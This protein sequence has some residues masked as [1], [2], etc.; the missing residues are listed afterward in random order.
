MRE[1]EAGVANA[2]KMESKAL[3]LGL[4]LGMGCGLGLR[5]GFGSQEE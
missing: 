2:C 1:T 3:G 5:L 4:R